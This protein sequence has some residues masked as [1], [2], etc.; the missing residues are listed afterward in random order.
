[1]Q[2]DDR[3][4][5]GIYYDGEVGTFVEIG[6][7]EDESGTAVLSEI[8]DGGGE[9]T[10]TAEQWQD[11]QQEMLPVPEAAVD[12]PVG[13]YEQVV[14]TLRQRDNHFDVGFIYADRMTQVAG[15][16]TE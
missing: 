1:M 3:Y 7:P 12:D 6:R 5:D 10:L 4:L 2:V 9:T 14:N 13:H 15:L 11:K 16:Q 8:R